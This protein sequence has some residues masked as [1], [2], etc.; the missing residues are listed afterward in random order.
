VLLCRR[1][2]RLL[3]E[4]GFTVRREDAELIFRTPHGNVVQPTPGMPVGSVAGCAG[5][6]R[7]DIDAETIAPGSGGERIDYDL[8]AFALAGRW[9]RRIGL[10][11]PT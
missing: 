2:H 6:G 5:G 7:A 9:E 10:L 1:H 3:H 4:G 11:Q 8:A